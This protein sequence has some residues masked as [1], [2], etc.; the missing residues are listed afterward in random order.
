MNRRI[1][2]A[3]LMLF[4]FLGL[5]LTSHAQSPSAFPYAKAVPNDTAVGT[6]EFTLTKINSSGNAVVMATTDTVGYSGVC[7]SNCGKSGT[8][9]IAFAGIVPLVVE[10][11]TTA[12]HYVQIGSTTGG[13]GHDTGATTYPSSG[14][15]VIG[16][17]QTGAAAA[18]MAMVDLNPESVASATAGTTTIASGTSALG[19]SAIAS[20]ACATAVTTTATG[21][22]STD[23]IIWTPNASIKAVT[24]YTP[25]TSGGLSIVAFPT[26]N[27]VNFDV[28]NWTSASITPGAVTLNF[29]VV[30]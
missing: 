30:R 18:G 19:T 9:W 21:T 26:T 28:C 12:G 29:R 16:K 4:A 17:V 22:A 25:S 20:G 11:T 2:H 24:G 23:A 5:S 10:N 3:C 6:T 14:G 7:I 1:L 8:A 13:D 27:N 15:D